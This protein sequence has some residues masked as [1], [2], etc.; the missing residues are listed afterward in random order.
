[1]VGRVIKSQE[2]LKIVDKAHLRDKTVN[3]GPEKS[4][5]SLMKEGRTTRDRVTLNTI[6]Q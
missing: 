6:G 3:F 5:R 2:V 4:A 1:M